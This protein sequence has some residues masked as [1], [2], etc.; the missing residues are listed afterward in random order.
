MCAL[1]NAPSVQCAVCSVQSAQ[2]TMQ[3]LTSWHLYGWG[4]VPP[5]SLCTRDEPQNF[6]PVNRFNFSC[7]ETKLF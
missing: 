5:N 6:G 4:W 3:K 7:E 1:H 2:C